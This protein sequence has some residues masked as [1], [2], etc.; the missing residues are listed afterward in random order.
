MF[1]KFPKF[2]Q[3]LDNKSIREFCK[4]IIVHKGNFVCTDTHHLTWVNVHGLLS[5]LDNL[6]NTDIVEAAVWLEG[7]VF[8]YDDLVKIEKAKTL[9][10][11]EDC[12]IVDGLRMEY[13]YTYS[14]VK[15][16]FGSKL[17]VS[18]GNG[19]GFDYPNYLD[20]IPS[21]D[22]Y[23]EG[24]SKTCLDVSYITKFA[25]LKPVS[26][27]FTNIFVPNSV[28][29]G[30]ILQHVSENY[31]NYKASMYLMPVLN[32]DNSLDLSILDNEL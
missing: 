23:N 31:P 8:H 19:E 21:I 11:C 4:Y 6:E 15:G 13:K 12:V 7:K 28:S 24:L 29:R 17:R 20:V 2:S 10:I 3:L 27:M 30:T 18:D 16:Y 25:A 14:K 5:V 26:N 32:H 22:T 1:K 9:T